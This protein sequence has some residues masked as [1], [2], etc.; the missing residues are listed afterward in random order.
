MEKTPLKLKLKLGGSGPATPE[1]QK[2]CSPAHPTI[3]SNMADDDAGQPTLGLASDDDVEEEEQLEEVQV[4]H[5]DSLIILI[6]LR[7][8]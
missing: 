2:G 3:I 4:K 5:V 1:Q 8:L 7:F 6:A